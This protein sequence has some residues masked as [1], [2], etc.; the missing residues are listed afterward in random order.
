[1]A[2]LLPV[3]LLAVSGAALSAT[4][5]GMPQDQYQGLTQQLT[6][7]LSTLTQLALALQHQLDLLAS[8]FLPNRPELDLLTDTKGGLC[9]FIQEECCF[10]CNE[11]GIVQETLTQL[12]E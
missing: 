3:S 12:K 9:L 7:D 6:V 4:S 2:I 11:T 5:M 1:M 8:E 10:Y